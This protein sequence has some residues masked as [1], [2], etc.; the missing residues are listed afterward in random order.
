MKKILILMA[1]FG[2]GHESI[3]LGIKEAI[4]KHAPGEYQVSIEDG[5]P[6]IF[7]DHQAYGSIP[8]IAEQSYKMTNYQNISK[9]F[10]TTVTMLIG[11]YLKKIILKHSPDLIIS[12]HALMTSEVKS[13]LE[14]VKKK[15]KLAIY[16][17]DAIYPHQLWFSEKNADLYFAPTRECLDYAL[18]QGIPK[19]KLIYTGWILREKYYSENFDPRQC[20]KNLG[21]HSDKFLIVLGGGGEGVGKIEEMVD[22]FLAN[23]NFKQKG[24]LVVVC[25]TNHKLLVKLQKKQRHVGDILNSFGFIY[26][27][28]DYKKAADLIC[29]K[30]GPNEIF[31]SILLEKPFV[32]HNYL[33]AHEIDNLRW[34]KKNNIG[35]ADLNP[36]KVVAN[37]LKFMKD[38]SLMKEKV[39]NIKKIKKDHLKTPEILA[40]EISKLLE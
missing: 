17:A 24:Q 22:L 1:K 40:R 33:W 28:S 16:Y 30:A 9:I 31:E 14:K 37:I 25:G 19:S 15:S 18:K 38:P 35:G 26:N 4:E 29:S 39:E 11:R 21:L 6:K 5:F 7:T 36:Q 20:K 32:A 34:V 2:G 12:D 3:A 10:H 13:V 8:F 27:L 23:K